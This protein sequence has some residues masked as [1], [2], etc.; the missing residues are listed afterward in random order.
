VCQCRLARTGGVGH[1]SDVSGVRIG[2]SETPPSPVH[3]RQDCNILCISDNFTQDTVERPWTG[4][5]Q[6]DDV[7]QGWGGVCVSKKSVFARKSLM[8]DPFLK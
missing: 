1:Q 6:T 8:D 7:D 2:V 4:S 5:F 3:G